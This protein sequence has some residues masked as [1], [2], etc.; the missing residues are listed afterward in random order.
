MLYITSGGIKTVDQVAIG[1][2]QETNEEEGGQ[3]SLIGT[4]ESDGYMIDQIPGQN[5]YGCLRFFSDASI[6]KEPT[7]T[8]TFTY[9]NFNSPVLSIGDRDGGTDSRLYVRDIEGIQFGE[10]QAQLYLN[11][12][13]RNGTINYGP[14]SIVSPSLKESTYTQL[15]LTSDD[16]PSAGLLLQNFAVTEEQ[17]NEGFQLVQFNSIGEKGVIDF[18]F[19][20]DNNPF[21]NLFYTIN[22]HNAATFLEG[23]TFN[24]GIY[25]N[26]APS[27]NYNFTLNTHVN[28]NESQLVY[29]INN[30]DNAS[31]YAEWFFRDNTY[32]RYRHELNGG[33]GIL[34]QFDLVSGEDEN[35]KTSYANFNCKVISQNEFISNAIQS[36]RIIYGEYGTFWRQDGTDIYLMITNANDQYGTFNALRPF[37]VTLSTGQVTLNNSL[38]IT[39]D[40]NKYVTI[41]DNLG[42]TNNSISTN[43]SIN[44]GQDLIANGIIASKNGFLDQNDD[45]DITSAFNSEYRLV[46]FQVNDK[47]GKT[48]FYPELYLNGTNEIKSRIVLSNRAQNWYPYLEIGVTESNTPYISTNVS[49][50]G[51]DTELARCDWIKNN[52]ISVN[53]GIFSGELI[54]TNYS[55]YR[56]VNGSYG[57]F[58]RNDGSSLYLMITNANDPYGTYNDFRPFQVIFSDGQVILNNSF[59]INSD[60]YTSIAGNV[61]ISNTG[62]TTNTGISV[63]GIIQCQNINCQNIVNTKT[64]FKKTSTTLNKNNIY[65]Q[66]T[67]DNNLIF[68]DSVNRTLFRIDTFLGP[69]NN[70]GARLL[71]QSRDSSAEAELALRWNENNTPSV[72]WSYPTNGAN[73]E[74]AR[75]DWV[76]NQINSISGQDVITIY[77]GKTGILNDDGT[78]TSWLQILF[79]KSGNSGIIYGS[80]QLSRNACASLK[81]NRPNL[82]NAHPIALSTKLYGYLPL[83]YTNNASEL[84]TYTLSYYYDASTSSFKGYSTDGRRFVFGLS[85]DGNF[86]MSS[87]GFDGSN[88]ASNDIILIQ[89]IGLCHV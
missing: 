82:T 86:L 67:Y 7:Q 45:L 50:T 4:K 55:S 35:D 64:Y 72:T 2:P 73:N 43:S 24:K 3:L 34:T 10:D 54:N 60:G 61:A 27:A 41:S 38:I 59:I 14:I 49:N 30:N 17:P 74:L 87:P 29:T 58:W 84:L 47:N 83:T 68:T 53:G 75:C 46:P 65:A 16:N 19:D 26:T 63:N 79:K 85:S 80:A 8:I 37:C 12:E 18:L 77:S 21:I 1:A 31:G 70:T 33:N 11:F 56:I 48:F 52:F 71:T 9:N 13:N 28:K 57:T 62:I 32:T 15:R 6:S 76:K 20:Q 22:C 42:I 25:L 23:A 39:N 44:V 81:N 5:K 51:N 78:D 36:Y 89:F 66:N 40:E 88:I 69:T